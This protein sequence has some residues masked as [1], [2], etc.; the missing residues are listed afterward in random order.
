MLLI[1][2][3]FFD[4]LLSM[5][6][7]FYY[8]RHGE[9]RFN[10]LG[11]MQGM[12]DSN[13]TE[14]GIEDAQ[15]TASVLAN[16]H[17]DHCFTSS[18][19]RAWKTGQIICKFQEV[20]PICMKGL[21]E[22]DFGDLD[23]EEIEKYKSE[24]WG[25]A[26]REDW[27]EFHGE[28]MEKFAIRS[29]E[30]FDEILSQCKDNDKVL[31]V[32]HGSFIMHLFTTLLNFDQKSYIQRCN[33]EHRPWMPNGGI[34]IFTYEDGIWKVTQEPCS[35]DEFR[36][37]FVSKTVHYYFVRHGETLFNKQYRLQG[38]CDSPLTNQGIQQ[39]QTCRDTLKDVMFDACYCSTSERT[40]DT[41][42]ILLEGK[43]IYIQWDDRLK[44]IDFGDLEASKFLEDW[45]EQKK[46]FDAMHYRDVGGEDKVDVKKRLLEFLWE[47][48]DRS[49]NN[50]MVLLVSHGNYY[51]MILETLFGVDVVKL[52][53][54]AH[55]NGTNPTPNCG[56]AQFTCKDSQW[57]L[58]RW[59]S[60]E[61]YE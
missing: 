21:K 48:Y 38:Q 37:K 45:D 53:D 16:I 44:E 55:K 20:E 56:I 52:F 3:S 27:S 61:K 25:D 18:S 24:V 13:L 7:E 14:K 51:M 6:V 4:T 12:C 28:T 9:T 57:I 17:F 54:E 1:N 30:A 11:R 34:C 35:Q 59:M 60:G 36:K 8:V 40:R 49:E 58:E 23:G 10:L 2:I 50:A 42:Q 26:M 31:L 39:A 29:Q 5:K 33:K 41:A 47:S 46:R 22:F 32:S 19:E 43:D 15:K